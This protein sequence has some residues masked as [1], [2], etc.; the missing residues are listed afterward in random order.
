MTK[1]TKITAALFPPVVLL[2]IG[3]FLLGVE[4]TKTIT[5]WVAIILGATGFFSSLWAILSRS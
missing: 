1:L 2:I 4:P 5:G 3:G